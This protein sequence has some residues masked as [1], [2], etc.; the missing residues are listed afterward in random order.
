MSKTFQ[1]L[2]SGASFQKS[3]VQKISHLFTPVTEKPKEK[4][5]HKVHPIDEKMREIDEQM[6]KAQEDEDSDQEMTLKHL[7]NAKNE[8]LIQL[9]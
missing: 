5:H 8:R 9:K 2:K 1:L 6:K 3:K 4:Q 7:T